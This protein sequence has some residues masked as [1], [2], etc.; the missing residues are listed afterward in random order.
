MIRRVVASPTKSKLRCNI[1]VTLSVDIALLSK[2]DNSLAVTLPR[3]STKWT[4]NFSLL[5][6]L[7]AF[8]LPKALFVHVVAAGCF[9][10]DDLFFF[11]LKGHAADG[12]IVFGRVGLAI[13]VDLARICGWYGWRLLEDLP[14]LGGEERELVLE[15]LWGMENTVHDLFQSQSPSGQLA[16]VKRTY[17]ENVLALVAL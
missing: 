9:A 5:R 7:R 1:D 8:P 15:M 11:G 13:A 10:V 17:V 6:F 4:R 2:F 16:Q 14:K 12:A 3:R